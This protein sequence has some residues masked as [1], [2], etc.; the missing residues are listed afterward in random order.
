[1]RVAVALT[2]SRADGEDLLQA[3]LERLLRNWHRIETDAKGYLWRGAA[4]LL[5]GLGQVRRSTGL[6]RLRELAGTGPAQDGGPARGTPSEAGTGL[7]LME[8]RS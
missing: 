3:A 2:G 1:M 7:Q 8:G 6:W 4:R 5:G